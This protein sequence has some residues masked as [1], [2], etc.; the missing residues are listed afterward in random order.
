VHLPSAF[1]HN[2]LDI[3]K[4]REWIV[5]EKR[6]REGMLSQKLK[7]GCEYLGKEGKGFE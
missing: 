5:W 4:G 7:K 3:F 2:H 1:S 6:A